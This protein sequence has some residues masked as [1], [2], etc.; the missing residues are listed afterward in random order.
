MSLWESF[1]RAV[2]KETV[3]VWALGLYGT[4]LVSAVVLPNFVDK[5]K[6]KRPSAPPSLKEV[7]AGIQKKLNN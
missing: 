5:H 7:M 1:T 3:L 2:Y 4:S 6:V